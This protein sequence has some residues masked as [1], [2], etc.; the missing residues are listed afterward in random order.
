MDYFFFAFVRNPW[1]RAVSIAS[2]FKYS[3]S[4]FRQRV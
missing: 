3:L 1:D 2:Y 4:D